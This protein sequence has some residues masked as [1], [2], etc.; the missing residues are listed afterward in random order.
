[1]YYMLSGVLRTEP[2]LILQGFSGVEEA[3]GEVLVSGEEGLELLGE[4]LLPLLLPLPPGVYAPPVAEPGCK[5]K[6][7]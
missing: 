1:M 4:E 3:P 7:E 6:C 2:I 5:P